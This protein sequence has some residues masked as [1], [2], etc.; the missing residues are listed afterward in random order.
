MVVG[1]RQHYIVHA[2]SVC[3]ELTLVNVSLIDGEVS[4]LVWLKATREV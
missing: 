1:K 3:I 2:E 4:D